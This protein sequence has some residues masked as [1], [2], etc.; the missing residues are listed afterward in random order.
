MALRI[1]LS[2]KPLSKEWNNWPK[3]QKGATTTTMTMVT[4]TVTMK[5]DGGDDGG[6]GHQRGSFMPMSVSCSCPSVECTCSFGDTPRTSG[7]ERVCDFSWIEFLWEPTFIFSW[8]SWSIACGFV[9]VPRCMHA[10]CQRRADSPSP[11][12]ET[13]F[14]RYA[15][16]MPSPIPG[17]PALVRKVR[18]RGHVE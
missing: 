6:D 3:A 15:T 10:A 8:L 13:D 16:K 2:K 9:F 17:R 14:C 4:V 18:R 5:D 1:V 7:S 12:L 11:L